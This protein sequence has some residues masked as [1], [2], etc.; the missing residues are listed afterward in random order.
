MYE[1]TVVETKE[2]F[3]EQSLED[4]LLTCCQ[5]E[6]PNKT[7]LLTIRVGA[8]SFPIQWQEVISRGLP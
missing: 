6:A 3:E 4:A 1:I 7:I 2:T 5:H 8:G